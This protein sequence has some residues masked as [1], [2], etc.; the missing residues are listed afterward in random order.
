MMAAC[1]QKNDNATL[2]V[3]L[4]NT[5][6]L[7]NFSYCLAEHRVSHRKKQYTELYHTRTP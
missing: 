1:E 3:K 6:D 4:T 5:T 7:A 2:F